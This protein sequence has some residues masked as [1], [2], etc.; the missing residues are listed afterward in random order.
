MPGV[1]PR[2]SIRRLRVGLLMAG[3]RPRS[4]YGGVMVRARVYR[5]FTHREAHVR[6]CCDAFG[7]VVEEIVRQRR[8]LED[9]LRCQP[10]FLTSFDPIDLHPGAPPVAERMARAARLA[11]VGPMAA[12]A[13]AMA[14]LAGRAG[15]AA[16]A[17]EAIIDNGGDIF[18]QAVEPVI[19]GLDAGAAKVG[20]Q[21]AFLLEPEETPIS[22][23][24]S[25]GKMGHSASL[26]WCD[27]ATIVARDAGLA[28]AA[29][30][31]A[32]NL[33]KTADDVD[34]ALERISGI[35]GVDGVLIVKD[36]RVGMVGRL[37]KLVRSP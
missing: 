21:L 7:A 18:I 27:L 19:I 32:G 23:C 3:E 17:P 2:M 4:P 10:E 29:A 14:E 26:G 36:D 37:P 35:D 20:N 24:S 5:V 13:G 12:V 25:S 8:V 16:G 30:T 22:I 1:H 9:Y 34:A 11:G 31:A 6:I 15:L 28:D 33:V